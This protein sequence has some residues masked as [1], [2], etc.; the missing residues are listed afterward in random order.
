[1]VT[2]R[3]IIHDYYK[4]HDYWSM[5]DAISASCEAIKITNKSSLVM[6][7]DIFWDHSKMTWDLRQFP[8]FENF[9][10]S[11]DE[12]WVQRRAET[13]SQCIIHMNPLR[14]L[15]QEPLRHLHS[16]LAEHRSPISKRIYIQIQ[17]FME[18]TCLSCWKRCHCP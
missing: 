16:R 18:R 2:G 10:D 1:M 4:W 3:E 11:L 13:W 7:Q 15:S 14:A 12:I 6:N 8:V 9:W 17:H 5:K